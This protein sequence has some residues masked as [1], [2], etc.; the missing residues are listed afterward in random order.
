MAGASGSSSS[1]NSSAFG[2]VPPSS[3]GQHSSPLYSTFT[4]TS[5][6]ISALTAE[7]SLAQ[8][9]LG[10]LDLGPPGYHATIKLFERTPNE[11]TI[12]LGPWEVLGPS[13]RRIV[14]QCSYEGDTLEH[15]LPSDTPSSPHSHP[16]TL[17]SHHRRYSSPHELELFVSFPL[18]PHR[19]RYISHT[20]GLTCDDFIE[21]KYEFT[22]LESSLNF[23]SDLR[24]R[25]LVDWFD[26]DVIWSDVHRRTDSYGNVRGL[27]TI[28]RMKLWRDRHSSFHYLSVYANHRRRWKEYLVDN[29]EREFRQRDDRHR[30]LQLTA[31]AAGSGGQGRRG[32][33]ASGSSG[34]QQP[35]QQQPPARRFSAASLF[36][37]SSRR[38]G[39]SSNSS[40]S[41]QQAN[42]GAASTASQNDPDIRYLGIQFSRNGNVQPG[43]EDYNR[44]IVRWEAAHD[45]DS[46]F[47]TPY[48][49]EPVELQ[50]P[51]INGQEVPREFTLPY[52]NGVHGIA[53]LPSPELLGLPPVAESVDGREFDGTQ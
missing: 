17:H 20:D 28:Q 25:D 27:G 33:A 4:P 15:Y 41:S 5:A 48:P 34:E 36:L 50:S 6:A 8:S 3:H 10:S 26:V 39:S 9:P 24:Q 1:F 42:G 38:G 22:T 21:V 30:R 13:P 2:G 16:Y 46:Q 52:V 23:Q 7:S 14:W 43:T 18:E 32:S 49:T 51:Y 29:F 53:E 19:I 12:Y 31:K 45:A 35:P 47:E 40:S 37:G 44:F 11:T